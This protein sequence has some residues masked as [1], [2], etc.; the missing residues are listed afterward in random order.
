MVLL[1]ELDFL[2]FDSLVSDHNFGIA[3]LYGR[4]VFIFHIHILSHFSVGSSRSEAMEDIN[5]LF[6]VCIEVF[7]DVEHLTVVL[8]FP[9]LVKYAEHFFQSVVHLSM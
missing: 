3:L 7:I 5:H 2:L 8:V 6:I 4:E 1:R 9:A